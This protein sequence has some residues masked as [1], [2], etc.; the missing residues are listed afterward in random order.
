M[1]AIIKESTGIGPHNERFVAYAQTV[2]F[3]EL[4]EHLQEFTKVKCTFYQPEITVSYNGSVHVNFSSENIAPQSGPFSVI[5]ENC[6]FASFSN[7]VVE[8]KET[9][10][11]WYWV[12]ANL[13]YRHVDGGSNGMEVCEAHY[14]DGAWRFWNAGE[15]R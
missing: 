14:R 8:D 2:D 11:L 12:S 5:L 9:G 7:Y 1:K 6:C 15:R 4:F 3:T 13:Q 10:E